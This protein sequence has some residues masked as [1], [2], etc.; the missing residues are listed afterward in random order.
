MIT[1]ATLT[2]VRGIKS[3][4]VADLTGLTILV[5]PN[6]SGKS[7]VLD[8]IAIGTAKEPTSATDD[9]VQ[10]RHSRQS[11]AR[12]LFPA[13]LN[14]PSVIK[15][16]LGSDGIRVTSLVWR[17]GAEATSAGRVEVSLGR[18]DWSSPLGTGEVRFSDSGAVGQSWADLA[19]TN[20]DLQSLAVDVRF[21][22]M[23]FGASGAP[24][25]VDVLT[26]AKAQGRAGLARDLLKEIVPSL[27]TIE[28]LKVGAGFGVGLV[29]AKSAVPLA[30]SGDGVR[31]LA[32]LALELA[33]QPGGL[34]LVEE[35]EVHQHPKSLR[36]SAKV[37]VAAVKRGIQVILA[38]HSLELIDNL[39]EFA[40]AEKVLEQLS[41]QR[42]LLSDGQLDTKRFPGVQA[43]RIRSELELELR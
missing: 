17:G 37:I 21:I 34:V 6:G 9:A 40:E 36:M 27:D 32:R 7:T 19:A 22:D 30:V 35:P 1:S 43:Q 13:Q 42:L 8:G 12:W 10:R 24:D 2:N 5:G 38:T 33:A 31:G 15:V 26:A 41:V 11:T 39:I 3:G 14:G 4:V 25:L 20:P 23:R 18:P 16:S 28:I 29:N